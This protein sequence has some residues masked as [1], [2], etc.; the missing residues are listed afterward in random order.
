LEEAIRKYVQGHN[1]HPKP[2]L[3][4][5]KA[6]DIKNQPSHTGQAAAARLFSE[7]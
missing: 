5:A 3:W 2:Y 6:R 1:Q 7:T 4:T